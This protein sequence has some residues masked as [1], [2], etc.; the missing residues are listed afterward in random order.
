MTNLKVLLLAACAPVIL[1]ACASLGA[2]PPAQ[3][4]APAPVAEAPRAKPVYGTF[5]F[6]TAGMDRSVK[7]GDD[8]FAYAN[9]TWAATT[10]IPADRSSYNTFAVLREVASKRT[11]ELIATAAKTQ[12]PAGSEARMIGD[13]YA[14]FMD[15]A[16]IEAKG[17][18]PLAP[19]LAAIAAIKTRKDLSAQLGATIR[20]DVDILNATTTK[21][22]RLFGLW[23]VEDLN[24]T[25]RYLPYIVQG[26]LGMPDRAYYLDA[27]AKYVDLRARYRTHV[28]N[29]L[30]LAGFSDVDA[31]AA[32]VVALETKIAA[33]HW[34]VA[35]TFE[36][37]KNNVQWTRAELA[38]KAPGMDWDA[39]LTAAG[40]AD[41]P[42]FGAWQS[43]AISGEA[44]LVG[45]EPI[46]AWQDYLAFHA[47]ERGSPYLSKAFV[48]ESFAFNATAL[49]G[50]PQQAERWKRGVDFTGNALGEAIGKL[51]TAKYFPPESKAEVQEMVKN[52][53][54]AFGKRIDRLDWMDAATKA[55]A[56]E[57]LAN[58]QVGVGYPDRW[59]DYSGL[60][61]VAG[62]AYGNWRRGELFEYRRNLA[63]LGG[64]VDRGEWYMTPQTVNALYA[65]MQ[66]SISFP[67]AILQA[68]FFDP[69]ADPAVNYGAI[70]GVIGHE[71]SHGFDDTGAL[72]D[73]KGNVRNWW[74][75]AD[76]AHFKASSKQL[77]EQYNRYK[78]LPDLSVN[79]ELTLGENIADLAGLATSY[80]AYHLSLNGA[81]A[82]VI[83]GVTA[84][85][86]IFLGWA[87]NYRGKYREAALRRVLLTDGHAPGEYRADTVRNLDAW[88]PAF[89]AKP[90]EKLYLAPADR[91][92]IW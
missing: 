8:F 85:Q 36:I 18:G 69:A 54:A 23:V 32:R 37:K 24:D 48:D 46:A 73:A 63:K 60:S 68:P 16:A 25:S 51:Y 75:D 7:P 92:K 88:Y 11:V 50:T 41:Q 3:L 40:L 82:P 20:A 57:K 22:E 27:G 79:G 4:P 87:Q 59:R 12:G 9:G 71:I 29:Q 66:N 43:S 2:A 21:T 39:F 1:S 89:D 90:G 14:S 28:A 47:V 13:Y 74:T 77:V 34:T 55:K 6:D 81:P 5:G 64:P 67:A 76:M 45:S 10:E 61:I 80:D 56:H 33:T 31:R 17:A 30:R 84:D 38:R 44:R 83:D 70:G 58:F 72:F 65:P 52:I 53:L 35:D 49:S 42:V 62:D 15:E 86:R 78:A 91:V 26:G 19:E